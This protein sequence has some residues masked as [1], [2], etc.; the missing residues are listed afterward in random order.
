MV[1]GLVYF[2]LPALFHIL[3][4]TTGELEGLPA[5]T[6]GNFADTIKWL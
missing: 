5:F 2:T 4:F 3:A 6:N 1:V